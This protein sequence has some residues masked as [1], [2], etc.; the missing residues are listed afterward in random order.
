MSDR[1]RKLCIMALCGMHLDIL[2][3]MIKGESWS[4]RKKTMSQFS[5]GWGRTMASHACSKGMEWLTY[6]PI[7]YYQCHE[8]DITMWKT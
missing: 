2:H 1:G 5:C 7:F 8:L 4:R 3:G 6:W